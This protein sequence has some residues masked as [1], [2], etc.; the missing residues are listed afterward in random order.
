MNVQVRAPQFRVRISP[1][2]K[3]VPEELLNASVRHIRISRQMNAAA[4][5]FQIG[6]LPRAIGDPW[7]SR[8]QPMSYVE[9]SMWV[10][11]RKPTIVMRG[12]VDT[13]AE[14]FSIEGGSPGRMVLI[15]G[16][17]Y[18][19]LLLVTKLF[20]LD[21]DRSGIPPELHLFQEWK[22]GFDSLGA[23]NRFRSITPTVKR[24]DST[25]QTPET[26]LPGVIDDRGQVSI[27]TGE[28][29]TGASATSIII[30]P[31]LWHAPAI[32]GVIYERF[33]EPQFDLMRGKYEGDKPATPSLSSYQDALD[34]TMVTFSPQFAMRT[35]WQP[36]M[37]IWSLF[38]TY[39]NAPWRE[40]FWEDDAT[41]PVLMTRPTPWRGES[42]EFLSP[43]AATSTTI[44]PVE[45]SD[46][47]AWTLSRTDEEVRN[48]FFTYPGIFAGFIAPAKMLA[49]T[50]EGLI[51]PTGRLF[52]DNPVLTTD[53]D[54][55]FFKTG[56][57]YELFGLRMGEF[58]SQYFDY[59]G[60]MP[61]EK[62]EIAWK[63]LRRVG[64]AATARLVKALG[65]GGVLENG[66]ITLKGNEMIR[67]GSYVEVKTRPPFHA[68]VERIQHEFTQGATQD[69]RF[70]TTLGVTRG[71]RHLSTGA[72]FA[73]DLRMAF[74]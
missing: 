33:F 16:R 36:Y 27:P 56:A 32:M 11:P 20:Y 25:E 18:G 48:F 37:D 70:V 39:Q 7:T 62:V 2:E 15:A 17:D 12:F 40:L 65:H 35:T 22:W 42:G 60:M 38:R 19:K 41:G 74:P 13:V 68:Y 58:P 5:A 46:V 73:K 71:E 59:D 53:E 66:S 28:T 57:D 26:V 23:G 50:Y 45:G 21:M 55:K 69:G 3:F 29:P 30:E 4:G 54:V 43:V 44:V 49:G 64:A 8:I 67:L 14:S 31:Y 1:I 47:I 9:I 61:K 6:L 34:E 51:K 10:P 24:I 72:P 63:D 52:G